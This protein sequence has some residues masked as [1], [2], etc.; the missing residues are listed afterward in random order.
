M[1]QKTNSCPSLHTCSGSYTRDIYC[2]WRLQ[3]SFSIPFGQRNKT[4]GCPSSSMLLSFFPDIMY[5]SFPILFGRC[6]ERAEPRAGKTAFIL[7]THT[8]CSLEQTRFFLTTQAIPQLQ[9]CEILP[10]GGKIIALS[11]YSKQHS[12][13]NCRMVD[14]V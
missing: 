9:S 7:L 10:S 13:V 11:F 1:A 12:M 6:L 14:G 3:Y 4:Y 8:M 2:N 5:T